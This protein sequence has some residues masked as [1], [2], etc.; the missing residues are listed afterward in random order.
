MPRKLWLHQGDHATPFG[1]RL[2]GMAAAD[3]PLVRPLAVRHPQRHHAE[4]RVDVERADGPWETARDWPVPGTRTVPLSLNAGPSGQPGG[5]GPLPRPGAPQSFTDEGRT[6][7]A[8][9]L[10]A[11]EDEPTPAASPT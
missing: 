10:L 9:Q 5:L 4:P 7:T 6:R 11:H 3:A 2:R 8:E 1:W